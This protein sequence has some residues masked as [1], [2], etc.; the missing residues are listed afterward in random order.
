MRVKERRNKTRKKIQE[1]SKLYVCEKG[2][3]VEAHFIKRMKLG[4]FCEVIRGKIDNN[5]EEE[6]KKNEAK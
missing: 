1:E 3:E 2:S 4:L 6:K 5:E